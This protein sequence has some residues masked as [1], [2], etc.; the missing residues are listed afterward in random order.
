MDEK[1]QVKLEL[2]QQE[3]FTPVSTVTG[4]GSA[5]TKLELSVI[6]PPFPVQSVAV[7]ADSAPASQVGR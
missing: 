4:T 7:P 5:A 3:H 2:T 6:V 1:S